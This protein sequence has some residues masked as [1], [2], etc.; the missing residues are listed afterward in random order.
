MEFSRQEYWNG[1]HLLL[2]GIFLAQELNLHLLHL[3]HWQDDSLP[4]SHLE[5]LAIL[6][7][8]LNQIMNIPDSNMIRFPCIKGLWHADLQL[9]VCM[10][11][12]VYIYI[13]IYIYSMELYV[14]I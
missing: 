5:N 12:C 11:V 3:L 7:I 14:Y 8:L 2:Q 4:L 9:Y 1:L 13:Y 10:C 6:E